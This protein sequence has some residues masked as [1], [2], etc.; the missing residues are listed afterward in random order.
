MSLRTK[1]ILIICVTVIAVLGAVYG[2]SRFTLLTGLSRIERYETEKSVQ[3]VLSALAQT[4]TELESYTAIRAARDDTYTFAGDANTDYVQRNLT[5]STFIKLRI[6]LMLF[7]D[8]SGQVIFGKA[9]DLNNQKVVPV[10]PQLLDDSARSRLLGSLPD[11]ISS[12]SGIVLLDGSPMIIASQPVLRSDYTGP[13]RGTLIMGR[14]LDLAELSRLAQLT[15]SAVTMLPADNVAEADFRNALQSLSA[16][17]PIFV[18]TLSTQDIA[19]YTLLKDITG[20]SVLILRVD[21][22]RDAYLLGQTAVVYNILSILVI[23]LLAAAIVIFIVQKQIMS[24]F[25]TILNGLNRITTTGN[26]STRLSIPGNDELNLVAKTTN[27][28]L[29]SLEES[30][31]ELRAREERY[32][33]LVENMRDIIFTTDLNFNFSYTSPSITEATGYT[34]EEMMSKSFVQLLTPASQEIAR[35]SFAEDINL[36]RTEKN[37]TPRSRTLELEVMCKD[38]SPKWFEVKA[39]FTRGAD[40]QPSGTLGVAR[41]IAE[42]KA[43]AEAL[44]QLYQA[45]R[46]FRKEPQAEITKRTEYTRALVHELKTPITPIIAAA[47]LLQEQ[48]KEARLSALVDSIYRSAAN[49]NRRID[50]LLDLARSEVDMLRIFP[51]PMNLTILLQ[52]IVGET[53]PLA[54]HNNQSLILDMSPSLPS[55]MADRDRLRQV[56]LNLLNNAFKYTP[57]GGQITLCARQDGNNLVIAISDTG[58]GMT[59]EQQKHL[60]DPYY[61]FDDDRERL[62]GLGLGLALVKKIVELHQGHIWVKSERD[63]GSTFSFSLPLAPASSQGT[64]SKSGG[65]T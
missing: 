32:R 41:D 14:Y 15:L 55:V 54:S 30:T 36:E 62:S 59:E 60:F 8:T 47:E 37:H 39:G 65:K 51:E 43:A 34:V 42:R 9:F 26:L 45:E 35:K 64:A 46:Y 40:G 52:E 11:N 7:V 12:A 1:T 63:K 2:T 58:R 33:L 50:E 19:G 5:D 49:L 29:A 3:R 6:N 57:T 24:R 48:V 61:R 20:S 27:G 13:V 31:I 38:G 23:A 21:V 16:G 17:T 4:V 56:I 44:E 53:T 28:L 25:A 18:Q 10:P 22:P